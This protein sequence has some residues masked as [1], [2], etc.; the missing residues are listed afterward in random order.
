MRAATTIIQDAAIMTLILAVIIQW[1]TVQDM[2]TERRILILGVVV[3][4]ILHHQAGFTITDL[5]TIKIDP[6]NIVV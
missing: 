2:F 3:A 6:N 4:D 1:V 5:I